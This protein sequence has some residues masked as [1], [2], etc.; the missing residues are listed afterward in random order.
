M[1][2]DVNEN[3]DDDCRV[4]NKKTKKTIGNTPINNNILDREIVVLLKY[5]S[6]FWRS[7]TL[8]LINC[9]IGF[10][11]SWSKDCTLFFNTP[12]VDVNSRF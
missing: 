3:T 5:L 8:P 4:N 11:L 10:D 9:K 6:N 1:N 12:E 2:D 7:L